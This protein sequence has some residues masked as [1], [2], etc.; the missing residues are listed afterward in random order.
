MVEVLETV[1]REVFDDNNYNDASI[2]NYV[3]IMKFKKEGIN[4]ECKNFRK[5]IK[6]CIASFDT[7]IHLMAAGD[8][9]A[10][11]DYVDTI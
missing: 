9:N 7:L 10:V 4:T 6:D 3:I 2:L 1:I 5:I 11:F 8:L